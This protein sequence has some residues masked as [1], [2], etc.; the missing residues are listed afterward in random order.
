VFVR[1]RAGAALG[2]RRSGFTRTVG[3]YGRYQPGGPELK[4]V[5]TKRASAAVQ[6]SPAAMTAANSSLYLCTVPQDATQSGRVGRKCFVKSIQFHY[7]TTLPPGAAIADDYVH[8]WIVQDMQT[9]G[10]LAAYADV[11][12]TTSGA[13]LVGVH[14]RNL[15]NSSRFKVLNHTVIDVVNPFAAARTIE[16]KSGFIKVAIPLEF[17]A[18][19]ITGVVA[20]CKSNSI[21]AIFG[22]SN[23]TATSV[24]LTG[25]WRI[26]YSDL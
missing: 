9:N 6:I 12:D 18:T 22:A 23:S 25:Q 13:D 19:A 10:V 2:P 16:Q 15:V 4:F 21:F 8:V 14:C 3:N 17:D 20:T 11:F 24:E 1:R 5:D 7:Q 26:K